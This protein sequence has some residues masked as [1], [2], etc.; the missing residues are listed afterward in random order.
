MKIAYVCYNI[1]EKYVTPSVQDEDVLLLEFLKGKGLDIHR[2]VWTN[3][4][5]NWLDYDLVL[6]KAPWDYHEHIAAFYNWLDMLNNASIPLLN[7]YGILKW[8]SDKHY[9]KEISDSGLNI[10]P[11]VFLEINSVLQ[12]AS[13]FQQLDS[14]KIIIKPCISGGAKNT[15]SLTPD[16]FS[17]HQK[18]INDLLKEEAFLVQPFIKEIETEGEWS[19]IFFDGKYSHSVLKKPRSGDFRVQH[20]YGGTIHT[21][22]TEVLHVET[23]QKFVDRFAKDCLYARVDGVMVNN[24]FLLMELELLEPFL[25]LSYHPNGFENYYTALVKFISQIDPTSVSYF[26]KEKG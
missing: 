19:F 2:E 7:P 23:A 24:E 13:I 21:D 25:F 10:I 22:K 1:Q 16:N 17:V 8:N 5:V 12:N 4:E 14:E 6:I 18:N 11:T 15:F 20:C 26:Q 3:Q 9:L